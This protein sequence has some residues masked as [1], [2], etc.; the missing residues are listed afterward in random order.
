MV[1]NKM[2]VVTIQKLDNY[3][4]FLMFSSSIMGVDIPSKCAQFRFNNQGV[5]FLK[6]PPTTKILIMNSTENVWIPD[7]WV[8]D[9]FVSGFQ[10]LFSILFPFRFTNI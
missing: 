2:A 7:I 10:M 8:P 4:R 5:S 6:N 3:V 9:M 1:K